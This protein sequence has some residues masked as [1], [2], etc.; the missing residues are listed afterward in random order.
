GVPPMRAAGFSGG[1]SLRGVLRAGS[2]GATGRDDTLAIL[3][4]ASIVPSILGTLVFITICLWFGYK[5]RRA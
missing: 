1:E 3:P 4:E 2:A 5:I